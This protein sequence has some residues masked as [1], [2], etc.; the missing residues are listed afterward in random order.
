MIPDLERDPD[1]GTASGY[2]LQASAGLSF[3]NRESLR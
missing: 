1:R 2:R 3:G